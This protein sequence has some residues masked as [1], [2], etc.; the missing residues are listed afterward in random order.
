M[1]LLH[2][3]NGRDAGS[4]V[5]ESIC[6]STKSKQVLLRSKWRVSGRLSWLGTEIGP[7]SGNQGATPIGQD[8]NKPETALTM[9]MTKDI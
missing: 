9:R 6:E 7:V 1:T 4:A 8:K 5:E 2:D 3:R